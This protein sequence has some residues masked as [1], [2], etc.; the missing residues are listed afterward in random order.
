MLNCIPHIIYS[1]FVINAVKNVLFSFFFSKYP[2][3]LTHLIMPLYCMHVNNPDTASDFLLERAWGNGA[4]K[5]WHNGQCL[6]GI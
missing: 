4:Y 3:K 6:D 2:A 1:I 5:L